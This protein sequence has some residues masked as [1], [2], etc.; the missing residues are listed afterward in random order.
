MIDQVGTV[1]VPTDDQ[2]RALAFYVEKLGF[3]K[4][5]DARYSGGRWIEVGPPGTSI[6][7]ALVPAG[8]GRATARNEVRCALA[9]RD[10]E[11]EHARLRALGVD[12]DPEIGRTGT[13]RPGL[14]SADVSV[15]DTQPPQVVFRDPEGNR[16]LLVEV[17][18]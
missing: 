7:I 18:P 14:I 13:R 17:R 10:I 2:E 8:E 11:K 5:V 6:N 12:V 9:T 4:R 16:F 1:F 3:A 15:P